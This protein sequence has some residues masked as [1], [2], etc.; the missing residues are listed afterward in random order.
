MWSDRRCLLIEGTM[1]YQG[2]RS[3][4]CPKPSL[5]VVL[6]VT[7]TV[8]HLA[9]FL[10]DDPL[11]SDSRLPWP[12]IESP[13]LFTVRETHEKTPEVQYFPFSENLPLLAILYTRPSQSICF[14]LG[15]RRAPASMTLGLACS[16]STF[17]HWA[18]TAWN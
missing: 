1:N 9:S 14:T 15:L 3:H 16:T 6:H 12:P 2:R 7:I 17:Q 5:P 11:L 10:N 8:R 18:S 13:S 4:L